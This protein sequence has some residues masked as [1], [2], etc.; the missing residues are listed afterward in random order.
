MTGLSCECLGGAK[1]TS[2]SIQICFLYDN[3]GSSDELRRIS[4]T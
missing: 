1:P 4:E 3:L 2:Q